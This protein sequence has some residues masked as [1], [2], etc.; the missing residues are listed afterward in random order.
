[1]LNSQQNNDKLL[2]V[3]MNRLQ[4]EEIPFGVFKNDQLYDLVTNF[5][6]DNYSAIVYIGD[7][8]Y[9]LII[10]ALINRLDGKRLPVALLPKE[11]NDLA[12]S[13]GVDSI[14]K[15][16]D[17]ILA[18]SVVKCDTIK[19]LCD[20]ESQGSESEEDK[21][22]YSRYVT[23]HALLSLQA[24]VHKSIPMLKSIN[25]QKKKQTSTNAGVNVHHI[26]V[27]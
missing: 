5:D 20:R 14:D 2:K 3:V 24:K 7:D 19:V 4:K 18:R 22:S 9:S 8:E 12:K 17:C 27:L 11:Y 26:A 16:I 1:M 10:N 25:G 21:F 13:L 23:S 6:I 15:A